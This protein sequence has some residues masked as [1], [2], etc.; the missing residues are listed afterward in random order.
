[1]T[2]DVKG[3][4]R[5][6]LL[7]IVLYSLDLG[8]EFAVYTENIKARTRYE[9]WLKDDYKYQLNR[10]TNFGI[11]KSAN[12]DKKDYKDKVGLYGGLLDT[13]LFFL[14]ISGAIFLCYLLAYL[15]F[16]LR[17]WHRAIYIEENRDHVVRVKFT[18]GFILSFALDIP[19]SCLAV[20]L[21]SL[22]QGNRG[23]HCWDC[24]QDVEK[25]VNKHELEENIYFSRVVIV[26]MLF[27][28][29]I[30]SIWK[31]ITTFYRWSKTDKVDCWQIRGCV[32]LFVGVFYVVIVMTP[33][34]GVFKYQFFMLPSQKE[35]VFAQFTD[36]LFMIGMLGWIIFLVVGCCFP[37]IKCIRIGSSPIM[38]NKKTNV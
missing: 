10:T 23:L 36:S 7:I 4:V 27:S 12:W 20:I 22:R 24:A 13:Y 29:V 15:W 6:Y 8:T 37:I 18:F 26:L 34:L 35:N 1:M 2:I 32:A 16:V 19:G 3:L 28:L 25:C 14:V 21:Y 11:C 30:V 5:E 38:S 17:S 33:S 9:K 31:G